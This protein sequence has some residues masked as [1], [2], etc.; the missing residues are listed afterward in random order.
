MYDD[1]LHRKAR[2]MD[3]FDQGTATLKAGF[4]CFV[5]L[6]GIALERRG[7]AI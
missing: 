6:A 5:S 2:C 7:G 1:I 3:G 4:F